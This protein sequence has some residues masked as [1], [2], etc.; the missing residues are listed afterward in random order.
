MPAYVVVQ[1]D[2]HDPVAY[3]GYK[4]LTPAT[5]AAFGGRFVVR[6]GAVTAL[7]GTWAPGR[8]VILEFATAE[9]ARAWWG[10]DEYGPA[11]ALR[12]ASASTEMILVEGVANP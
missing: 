4:A 10:S 5:I 2:V 6:G 12:Q 8:L 11:K 1:I 7:E 9:R 3:E